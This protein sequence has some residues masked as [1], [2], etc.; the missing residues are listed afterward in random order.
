MFWGLDDTMHS[1]QICCLGQAPWLC[2]KTSPLFGSVYRIVRVCGDTASG[3]CF[4]RARTE[5]ESERKRVQQN[6]VG[7]S[8]WMC[9]RLL[10]SAP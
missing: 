6:L 1:G 7:S 4:L 8:W 10:W 5:K 2:K 3:M 9:R